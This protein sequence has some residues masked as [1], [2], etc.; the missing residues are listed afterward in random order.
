MIQLNKLYRFQCRGNFQFI[1]T[2]S[3]K[4]I[5]DNEYVFM[6]ISKNKNGDDNEYIA[7]VYSHDI[8]SP[9]YYLGDILVVADSIEDIEKDLRTMS[10]YLNE[11]IFLKFADIL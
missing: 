2:K 4:R 7:K 9:K 8:I 6:K 11:N 10:F 5:R 3:Q 1:G